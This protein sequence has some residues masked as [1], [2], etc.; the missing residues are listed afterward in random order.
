MVILQL[1]VKIEIKDT[2]N[3]GRPLTSFDKCEV[4]EKEWNKP[5]IDINSEKEWFEWIRKNQ[6][7]YIEDYYEKLNVFNNIDI[8]KKE[9]LS[10]YIYEII[11]ENRENKIN[12][13]LTQQ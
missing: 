3:V 2:Y 5:N 13:V 6:P 12:K 11:A 1:K 10:D 7:F 9:G 8:L 4:I